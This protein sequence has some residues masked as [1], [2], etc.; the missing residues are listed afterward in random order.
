MIA[1]DQSLFDPVYYLSPAVDRA[2]LEQTLT[3]AFAPH[4]HIVFPP[5][6]FDSGLRMLHKMGH[7]GML[8]ERL[9]TPSRRAAT[10]AP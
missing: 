2:A 9:L 8:Y 10:R 4:R 5:D 1:P 3:E 7:I 6:R